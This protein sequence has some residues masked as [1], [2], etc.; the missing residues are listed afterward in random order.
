MRDV[1][2]LASPPRRPGIFV[3]VAAASHDLGDVVTELCSH[4]GE[5]ARPS[6]ILNHV[7]QEGSDNFCLC[8]AVLNHKR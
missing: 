5:P 4:L 2:L 7:V 6:P 3:G 1:C 8:S